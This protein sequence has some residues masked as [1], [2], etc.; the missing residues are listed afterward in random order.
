MRDIPPKH[1]RSIGAS[2]HLAWLCI[3]ASEASMHVSLKPKWSSDPC[4]AASTIVS[5]TCPC[6]VALLATIDASQ[7][8]PPS[9][10]EDSLLRLSSPDLT[11]HR[12]PRC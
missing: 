2:S 6:F 1:R 12:E 11:H 10:R 9:L 8:G 7:G 5:S 3:H 4:A